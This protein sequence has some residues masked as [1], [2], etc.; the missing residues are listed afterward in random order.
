MFI[1]S[2]KV[3]KEQATV[4]VKTHV[5]N[6]GSANKET[7]LLTEIVD[8]GGAVAASKEDKISIAGGSSTYFEQS[9][10]VNQPRLWSPDTPEL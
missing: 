10:V 1:T 7:T 5:E 3:A 6:E 4:K 8:A 9:L 2:P